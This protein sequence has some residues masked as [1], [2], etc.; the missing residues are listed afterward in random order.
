MP[1]IK[2]I[3]VIRLSAMGDVAM[4]VPVLR[5]F[6]EQYPDIK[7]TVLTREFF[8]PFFRDLKNVSVF[9]ADVKRKHK[10]VLGLY[11]LSK[12][13]KKL[14]TDAVADLHNVLRSNILKFFLLGIKVVQIDKGRKAK[15]A[16]ISGKEV[17]QL[18]TTV[19][20]YADVFRR[21]GFLLDLSNPKFPEKKAL[22]NKAIEIIGSDTKEWIG[23]APFAA[24]ESKMYPLDLLTEVINSISKKYRILLFGG[25]KHEIE[26][27]NKLQDEFENVTSIAGKLSLKEEIDVISNLDVMLSA[28]SGN[29]HIAAMLGIKVVT[30][31]GVTHP[32]AGFTPFNQPTDYCL[33]P[34]RDKFPKIPTSIYGNKYPEN[35]KEAIRSIS[36]ETIVNKINSI[37]S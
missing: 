22:S 23:I 20:R 30:I 16:L 8:K 29:G 18:K 32:F 7:L 5:A 1:N 6:Q 27:L 35:Y 13:L 25:G 19:E 9:S 12:E 14:N 21:L 33:L 28:D 31:W 2:H 4:T 24:Y 15:Q 11:K 3:L 17:K 34:D 10:G 36:P 26:Q 37:L